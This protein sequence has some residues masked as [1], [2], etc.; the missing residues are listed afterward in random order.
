MTEMAE[1]ARPRER[2]DL[3]AGLLAA[4]VP[5]A[6]HIYLGEAKRGI[7][8]AVGVL[9]LFFGGILLGGVDVIDSRE[10]RLWFYGQALVGPI[11]FG[12]DWYH[13]NRLKAFQWEPGDAVHAQVFLNSRPTS[14]NPGEERVVGEITVDGRQVTVPL[15]EKTPGAIPPNSKSI[16][17]MNEL[18]T[19]FATIAGMLNLIIFIDALLPSR[20]R[21]R[22]GTGKAPTAAGDES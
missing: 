1:T 6:G 12:V 15:R 3:L 13:Q 9:G 18:G 11:A 10:D 7:L 22:D 17:R 4:A 2:L 16:G 14:L 8:A 21:Q 5:G 19:L 20:P